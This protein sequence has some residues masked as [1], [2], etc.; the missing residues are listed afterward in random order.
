MIASPRPGPRRRR[1]RTGTGSESAAS[2]SPGSASA[3]TPAPATKPRRRKNE[4]FS[5]GR[6]MRR[7]C[8]NKGDKRDRPYRRAPVRERHRHS[9][10]ANVTQTSAGAE[11]HAA[12]PVER[13]RALALVH[14]VGARAG[15]SSHETTSSGRLMTNSD[16]PAECAVI[17]CAQCRDRCAAAPPITAPIV[18]NARDRRSGGIEMRSSAIAVGIDQRAARRHQE[19]ADDDEAQSV[20]ASAPTIA[21]AANIQRPQSAPA[22]S[23][24]DR[25]RCRPALT[26]R[27]WR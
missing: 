5:T 2:T 26:R 14:H 9:R 19:P 1:R 10:V 4:R 20:G 24:R 25:P 15:W 22:R 17:Q 23:R 12:R 3:I 6:S 13:R 11:Q 16:A 27:A 8:E 18:P 7:S 21:P